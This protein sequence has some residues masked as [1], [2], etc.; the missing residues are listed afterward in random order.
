VLPELLTRALAYE[1]RRRAHNDSMSSPDPGHECMSF[2]NRESLIR[3]QVA[4]PR[5]THGRYH[6]QSA[7][8]TSLSTALGFV[9]M[10]NSMAAP[11]I[12]ARC[13]LHV[14]RHGRGRHDGA[15]GPAWR[16]QLRALNLRPKLYDPL[17][18]H[19]HSSAIKLDQL[20][21]LWTGRC[22][23]CSQ[24]RCGSTAG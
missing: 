17:R 5:I 20:A 14:V 11:G 2:T 1:V 18:K 21:V 10:C 3:T 16:H 12:F 9:L 13:P 4:D 22:S 15:I 19:F 6:A 8:G 7:K 23:D 24:I